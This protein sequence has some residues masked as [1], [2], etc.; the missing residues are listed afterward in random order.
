MP[1]LSA[2]LQL[3]YE[4]FEGTHVSLPNVNVFSIDLHNDPGTLI[5]VIRTSMCKVTAA[6][7]S[8]R[9]NEH[10]RDSVPRHV[11]KFQMLS[12]EELSGVAFAVQQE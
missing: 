10:P 11:C 8:K 3:T 1:L 9:G 6:K 7:L 5:A 4:E 12:I 2:E